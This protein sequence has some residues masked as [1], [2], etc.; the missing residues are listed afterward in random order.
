MREQGFLS[1]SAVA[2]QCGVTRASVDLWIKNGHVEHT[3]VGL[4]IYI[5]RKSLEEFLGPDGKKML[6]DCSAKTASQNQ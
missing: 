6:T 3:R 5:Q 2:Q 4:R 1:V